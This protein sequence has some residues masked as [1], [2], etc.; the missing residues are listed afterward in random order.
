MKYVKKLSKDELYEIVGDT[1]GKKF[2]EDSITG[3]EFIVEWHL[4]ER[5]NVPVIA[6]W[7]YTD[8]G[9]LPDGADITSECDI[10]VKKTKR[11]RK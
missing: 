10:K 6:Q 9:F 3:K 4:F 2:I 1:D 11:T 5:E 8:C 7:R